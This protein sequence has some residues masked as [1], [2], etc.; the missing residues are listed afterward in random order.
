MLQLNNIY[1]Q[2]VEQRVIILSI[3][4]TAYCIRSVFLQFSYSLMLFTET[5][6]FILFGS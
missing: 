3:H 2:S 4:I 5:T 6:K 1:V